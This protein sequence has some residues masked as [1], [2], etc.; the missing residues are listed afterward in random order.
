MVFEQHLCDENTLKCLPSVH[1]L[2]VDSFRRIK[3]QEPANTGTKIPTKLFGT[4]KTAYDRFGGFWRRFGTHVD[5][6]VK[7]FFYYINVQSTCGW[8]VR[9]YIIVIWS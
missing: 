3:T 9:T 2:I 1:K 4:L 8:H 7:N 5:F 6:I